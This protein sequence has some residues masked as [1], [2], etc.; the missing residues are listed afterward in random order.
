MPRVTAPLQHATVVW[1]GGL[2][3]KQRF[4]VVLC[5]GG[6]ICNLSAKPSDY[7]IWRRPRFWT[8][9]NRGLYPSFQPVFEADACVNVDKKCTCCDMLVN[10]LYAKDMPFFLQF[11]VTS[12]SSVDQQKE[13]AE[14]I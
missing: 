13:L 2:A 6:R 4:F 9:Y 1:N 10:L 11:F 14:I 12:S 3:C 5:S 8:N 7:L